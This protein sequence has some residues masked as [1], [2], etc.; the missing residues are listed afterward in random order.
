MK[1]I[2]ATAVHIDPKALRCM[3]HYWIHGSYQGVFPKTSTLIHRMEFFTM[4]Y[5]TA[6]PREHA[7]RCQMNF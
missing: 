3:I 4:G 6:Q 5:F 2:L 7:Q 1:L